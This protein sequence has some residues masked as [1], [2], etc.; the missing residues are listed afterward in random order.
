MY[1]VEHRIPYAAWIEDDIEFGE[2]F[3]E[4]VAENALLTD[5]GS[6]SMFRMDK[7]GEGYITSLSSA[8]R[9]LDALRDIGIKKNVDNALRLD[10][11]KDIGPLNNWGRKDSPLPPNPLFKGKPPWKRL[12]KH[13]TGDIRKT[14][15]LFSVKDILR[16]RS[17]EA[18]KRAFSEEEIRAVANE[19]SKR[20]A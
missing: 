15:W 3:R 9:T 20:L 12:L 4:Y 10:V 5:S 11:G 6:V 19:V 14:A 17:L 18:N 16:S 13:N 1:Q 7:W 8:I 2:G